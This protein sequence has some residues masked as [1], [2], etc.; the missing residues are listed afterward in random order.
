MCVWIHVFKFKKV[1]KGYGNHVIDSVVPHVVRL[2]LSPDVFPRL[3]ALLFESSN[4][5][6]GHS[7][8]IVCPHSVDYLQL[9]YVFSDYRFAE[10]KEACFDK[11]FKHYSG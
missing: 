3:I 4:S 7:Q 9:Y 11:F 1:T 6:L 8:T 5:P 2:I 10:S